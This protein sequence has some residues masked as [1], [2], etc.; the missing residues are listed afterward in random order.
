MSF[1]IV[2]SLGGIQFSTLEVEIYR[3]IT[4]NLNFSIAGFLALI[5]FIVLS[6]VGLIYFYIQG[7][8]VFLPVGSEGPDGKLCSRKDHWFG[9]VLQ[10]KTES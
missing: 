7:N 2:I 6:L 3:Q 1:A 8:Q 9:Q 4:R 5:Q 10:H